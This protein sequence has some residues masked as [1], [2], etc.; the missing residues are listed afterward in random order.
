MQAPD[1]LRSCTLFMADGPPRTVGCGFIKV[2]P[3]YGGVYCGTSGTSAA[4]IMNVS[5]I[6][7]CNGYD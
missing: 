4:G 7:E 3:R 6:H 2:E 5:A 1:V